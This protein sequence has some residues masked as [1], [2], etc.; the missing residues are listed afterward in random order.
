MHYAFAAAFAAGAT[1]AV[2]IGT[3]CPD[4]DATVAYCP[5]WSVRDL[6]G[7][8]GGIHQWAGHALTHRSP[9]FVPTTPASDAGREEVAEWY[10]HSA[11]GLRDVLVDGV[12]LP[13]RELAALALWAATS[14][15]AASRLFR[16]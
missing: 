11:A 6:A 9:S 12:S 14:L 16:W 10:R 8:L 1:A 13:L 15:A 5:G 3:D 4:L 7:H 2:I